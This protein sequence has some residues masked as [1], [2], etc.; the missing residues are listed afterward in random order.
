MIEVR[1]EATLEE[2]MTQYEAQLLHQFYAEY[3][4]PKISTTA[5]LSHTA[6]AN[7]LRQYG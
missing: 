7:K 1:E 5:R 6:V 3:R 4:V 2:M